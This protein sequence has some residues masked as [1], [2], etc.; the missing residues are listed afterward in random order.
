MLPP[1]MRKIVIILFI[2]FINFGFAQN[3]NIKSLVKKTDSLN[4][5]RW[6]LI[7]F[8]EKHL[9]DKEHLA[10]FFYY[11][12]GSNIT[13]DYKSIQE[14][15]DG[16]ITLE[17]Y[18]KRQKEFEVYKNRKGVCAG[19]ANLFDWFMFWVDI[20]S[21]I[22]SGHIRDKRN[23]YI[24]L[25]LDDDHRHAWNAI[26]INE[27]WLL[28]DSTWGTS[29]D[30]ETADYYFNV[31]PQRAI[32]T[33]YPTDSKWQLLEKP[34]SLEDYNKSKFIEPI[35]F[36][37]GYSDN[38]ILKKDNKYY[39]FIFK[40]NP[41]NEWVVNLTFSG[42]N[43]NFKKIKGLQKIVQ[44]GY[45]YLRFYK[46]VIPEKTFFKV[47]LFKSYNDE[48]FHIAYKDVINFKI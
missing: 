34:L 21:A 45:T 4:L 35:W 5:D 24:E 31:E 29:L 12:I 47:N 8:A 40:N 17:E 48:R 36:K 32:I 23:H 25:E 3:E 22:I 33:H 46:S 43:R 9:E 37:V 26:E 18:R 28:V 1:I 2:L 16:T 11:W 13:Y 30:H 44:E 7:E 6:E 39:Y 27:K 41:N 19:Y 20:D 10:K 15:S 38:P 14:E 42:D